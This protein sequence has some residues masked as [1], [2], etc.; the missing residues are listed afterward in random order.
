MTFTFSGR[1]AK[2]PHTFGINFE[3]HND[4]ERIVCVVSS[5]ALQ[6][7]Q[8]INPADTVEAQFIGNQQQFQAIAKQLI[9]NGYHKDG[10]LY[11]HRKHLAT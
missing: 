5:E 11:I 3:A 4:A 2:N 6:D 7:V 10:F 8:P 9:Q 1:W